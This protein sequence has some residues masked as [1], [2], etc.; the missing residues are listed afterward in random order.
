MVV[1]ILINLLHNTV[2]HIDAIHN[3]KGF[4]RS[5]IITLISLIIITNI[6]FGR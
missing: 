6:N 2:S 1:F 3:A 4:G 5:V